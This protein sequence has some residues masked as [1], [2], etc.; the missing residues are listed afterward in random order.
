MSLEQLTLSDEQV[1]DIVASLITGGDGS[2]VAYDDT[3]DTLTVSLSD[4]I[5]VNTLEATTSITDAS[6][7]THTGELADSSDVSSIQSSS[8]VTVTDAQPGTVSGGEFLK[9]DNGS[10][11]G[12]NVSPNVPGWEKAGSQ[13]QTGGTNI[14]LTLDEN[15]FRLKGHVLIKDASFPNGVLTFNND[16]N[17]EYDYRLIDGTITTGDR[18]FQSF[19]KASASPANLALAFEAWGDAGDDNQPAVV[20]F[21]SLGEGFALDDGLEKGFYNGT[22]PINSIQVESDF[23][24]EIEVFGKD[25]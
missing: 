12:A 5:S 1:Q 20:H 13:S 7:D 18:G 8:D 15:Y 22:N 3:N 6:G 16:S 14:D 4:S 9:N 11:T 24:M 10:L 2:D 21:K 19:G 17:N 23:D 25:I